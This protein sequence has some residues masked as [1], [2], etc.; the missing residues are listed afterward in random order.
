[1]YKKNYKQKQKQNKQMFQ[2]SIQQTKTKTHL[3]TFQ[4]KQNT[5]IAIQTISKHATNKTKNAPRKRYKK[6][7]HFQR[8]RNET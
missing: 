7:I 5:L 4:T 8:H 3:Y 6:W 1:M 2:R